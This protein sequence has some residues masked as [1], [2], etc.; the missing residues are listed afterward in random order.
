[1]VK[2]SIFDGEAYVLKNP[3]R[4]DKHLIENPPVSDI[5]NGP[6]IATTK[7]VQS[8]DHDNNF[9]RSDV[10]EKNERHRNHSIVPPNPLHM[11]HK[12]ISSIMHKKYVTTNASICEKSISTYFL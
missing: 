6:S 7:T 8:L 4:V 10:I 11:S 5:L 3:C 1:M 2:T 9:P 12:S